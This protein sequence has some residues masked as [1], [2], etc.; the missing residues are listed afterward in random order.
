[1]QII[2]ESDEKYKYLEQELCVTLFSMLRE[3]NVLEEEMSRRDQ[4]NFVQITSGERKQAE[5]NFF[6]NLYK[7]FKERYK[8]I[9]EDKCTVKL[10]S[11]GYGIGIGHPSRYFYIDEEC[12]VI[13]SM[14]D[15]NK[16][17]LEIHYTHGSLNCKDRFK[18]VKERGK[19]LINAIDKY[20]PYDFVWPRGMI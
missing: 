14:K 3:L 16:A 8:K 12:V 10:L 4:A 18:F 2:N 15:A 6:A 11:K 17:V 13:F 9:V 20:D 19:W 5:P 1:M 7:E